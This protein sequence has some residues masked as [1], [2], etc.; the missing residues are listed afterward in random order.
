M[1]EE[2]RR[3]GKQGSGEAEVLMLTVVGCQVDRVTH[4]QKLK[5]FL[6]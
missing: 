5:R 6:V 4:L 1:Q 2:K 3:E